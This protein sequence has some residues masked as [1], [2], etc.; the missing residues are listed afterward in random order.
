MPWRPT[1]P[2]DQKTPCIADSLRQTRSIIKWCALYGVRRTTGD[3]W[4][5][6]ALTHGP[7]G[8]EE[9]S[10]QPHSSPHPMPRQVVEA[11][12]ER[13]RHHPSWG[14]K[15]RPSMLQ[16][17]HPTWPLPALHGLRDLQPTWLGAPDTTPAT[18]GPSG[19]AHQP[20][21]RP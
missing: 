21:P 1:S 5:A 10:R 13:R 20:A 15:Q 16:Q 12:L 2:M 8:L 9:R 17:R 19:L 18:H 3:T 7:L 4:I 14:A 6:R 11:C